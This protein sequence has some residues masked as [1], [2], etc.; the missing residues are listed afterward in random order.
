MQTYSASW[1]DIL[2]APATPTNGPATITKEYPSFMYT[3]LKRV[4]VQAKRPQI[5]KLIAVSYT[6]L[7]VYK[8]QDSSNTVIEPGSLWAGVPAKFIKKIPDD[9]RKGI[10]LYKPLAYL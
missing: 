1:K 3:I 8:R 4:N 7:D 2:A 9:K 10:S 5:L 6:H